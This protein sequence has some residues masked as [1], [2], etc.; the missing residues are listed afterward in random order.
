[1]LPEYPLQRFDL[2]VESIEFDLIGE[3]KKAKFPVW[4]FYPRWQ[5]KKNKVII[6][7]MRRRG[8][9]SSWKKN[10]KKKKP[11][12]C[13]TSASRPEFQQRVWLVRPVKRNR[14]NWFF[15]FTLWSHDGNKCLDAK[16]VLSLLAIQ[17]FI[18]FVIGLVRWSSL[19]SSLL[20][21]QHVTTLYIWR[22]WNC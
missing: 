9:S 14:R 6:S 5:Q 3:K 10:Q 18:L 4:T 1:M 11:S 7:E 22:G 16:S 21:C 17:T 20:V 8:D 2:N 15:S 19:N 12:V 13:H